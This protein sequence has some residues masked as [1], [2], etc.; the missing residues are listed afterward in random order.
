MFNFKFIG[1]AALLTSL[2]SFAVAETWTL[3]GAA[4]KV[5]FGSIKNDYNGEVHSFKEISGSVAA[6]GAVGVTINLASVETLIDIRN[7]RMVE[8]VFQNAATAT[9]SAAIDMDD[10]SS[11]AVGESKI[12]EADGTISLVGEELDLYTELFITRISEDRVM[13][14]TNDMIMLTTADLELTAGIDKLMEIAGL[15]RITRVSPITLRLV[16]DAAG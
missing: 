5:A 16:F 4:S 15:E 12:I 13:A 8:H 10:V 9:I 7:E 11:L 1:V 14:T 2:A 6:D 3:D